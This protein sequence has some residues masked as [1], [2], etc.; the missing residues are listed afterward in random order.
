MNR[1]RSRVTQLKLGVDKYKVCTPEEVRMCGG[2][3][4]VI[5]RVGVI[6]PEHPGRVAAL[7]ALR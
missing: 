6:I 1:P 4:G 5:P 2:G 3:I 7:G